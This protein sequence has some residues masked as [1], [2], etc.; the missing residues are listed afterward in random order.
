MCS[1]NLVSA[2]ADELRCTA[3][4]NTAD[5]F[6]KPSS[7]ARSTSP[8]RPALIGWPT[9][10]FMKLLEPNNA[11]GLVHKGLPLSGGSVMQMV[12][13]AICLM[14]PSFEAILKLYTPDKTF[15]LGAGK[16]LRHSCVSWR[17]GC[18]DDDAHKMPE[19]HKNVCLLTSP[20]A[21]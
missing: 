20:R 3:F 11:V 16:Y 15:C 14:K 13:L 17:P 9:H 4:Y 21:A 10:C 2:S 6:C 5:R 8:E 7:R 1:G 19:A 12:S 18:I